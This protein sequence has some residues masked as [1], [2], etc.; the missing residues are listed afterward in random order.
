[1]K[2]YDL[3]FL[4]YND[5]YSFLSLFFHS[6]LSTQRPAA[7]LLLGGAASP[8]VGFVV[9]GV[10]SVGGERRNKEKGERVE[11]KN[12]PFPLL[13]VFSFTSTNT[14]THHCDCLF[15]LDRGLSRRA[16]SVVCLIGLEG[17]EVNGEA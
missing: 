6:L 12:P 17:W 8:V 11:Q 14:K 4:F 7:W 1:M 16:S 15:E 13:S 10:G 2:K 9:D 3:F 5:F